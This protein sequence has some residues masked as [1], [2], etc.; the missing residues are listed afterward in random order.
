MKT[1]ISTACLFARC[2]TEQAFAQLNSLGVQNTEI[3][4]Q[5]FYEYRPEFAKKYRTELGNLNVNSV[6]VTTS[7]FEPQ[8]FSSTRRSRGDGFY[9]LD[10]LMRSC[11]LFGA[12]NYTMHGIVRKDA[13]GGEN[14]DYLGERINEIIS[15]CARYGVSLCLENVCW[16]LYNRPGVFSQLKRRADNLSGV[17]DLKQAR[18]SGYPYQMYIKEMSNSIAYAHLSDVDEKGKMCLPGKGVCDFTE[19]IKCL[20]GEGFDGTCLIEV[21]SDNYGDI[22]ELKTSLEYLDEI[23]YKIK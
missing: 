20:K 21:Y 12:K 10:Q 6:H 23:I 19:I 2:E 13:G 4:L 17:F 5:T 9:W 18:R 7:N 15:F 14:F 1:G 16:C 22:S 8:L 11:Q 3:F